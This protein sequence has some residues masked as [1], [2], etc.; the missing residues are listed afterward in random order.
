M[1]TLFVANV[2]FEAS[3]AEVKTLFERTLGCVIN[4]VR[5]FRRGDGSGKGQGLV[6]VYDDGDADR[7][8]KLLDGHLFMGRALHVTRARERDDWRS[9]SPRGKSR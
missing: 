6:V 5:L 3:D 1:K 9:L 8:I 4:R 2:P 7:A